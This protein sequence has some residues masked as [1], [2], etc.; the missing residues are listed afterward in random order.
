MQRFTSSFLRPLLAGAT[1]LAACLS[2]PTAQA[3]GSL[4]D[5]T[6]FVVGG[7]TALCDGVADDTAFLQ[8]ALTAALAAKSGLY[9]PAGTKCRTRTT[10]TLN[11]LI[12]L[13]GDGPSVSHLIYAPLNPTTNT[14]NAIDVIPPVRPITCAMLGGPSGSIAEN[15]GHTITGLDITPE[16]EDAGSGNGIYVFL[17][18]GAPYAYFDYSN[19]RIGRFGGLGL[20]MDNSIQNEDGI[21]G[22]RITNSL[23]WNGINI[24]NI[25]DSVH[26][27]KVVAAGR[28]NVALSGLGGARQVSWTG[29]Q[30]ST[31]NGAFVL[32]G[33]H[34]FRARDVWIE[35]QGPCT[36]TAPAV[37][38][39][40]AI[41]VLNSWDDVFEGMT[42]NVNVNTSL[43]TVFALYGAKDTKIINNNFTNRGSVSHIY[44]GATGPNF[45]SR[46]R[47]EGNNYYLQ[48]DSQPFTPQVVFDPGSN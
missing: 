23:I 25:G 46:T 47:I 29:G 6:K 33:V 3:A 42:F 5:V 40:A 16:V 45:T 32:N 17:Q 37:C 41:T 18:C 27:D 10:L 15:I 2:A 12:T 4:I 26:F 13:K 20:L 24:I 21:F 19:L 22:G 8:G 14:G 35:E 48:A 39:T 30:V 31:D 28:H 43:T 36:A 34:G 7:N 38:L 44:G 1:A 9:F 11:K